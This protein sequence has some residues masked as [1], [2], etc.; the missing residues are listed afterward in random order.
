[1]QQLHVVTT[2][3][4]YLQDTLKHRSRMQATELFPEH[5]TTYVY[6]IA[7]QPSLLTVAN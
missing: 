2:H 1:M 4:V 5:T 7:V 3:P 6:R